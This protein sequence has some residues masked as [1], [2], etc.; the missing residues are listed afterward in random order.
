MIR[1][2]AGAQAR[3]LKSVGPAV[4]LYA[5][6]LECLEACGPDRPGCRLSDVHRNKPIA[7]RLGAG[8][9]TIKVRRGRV[10]EEIQADSVAELVVLD[11]AAR[12]RATIVPSP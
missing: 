4:E 1:R 2:S 10:R 6:A 9:R 8:E 11:Q 5:D 3:L 12:V 7:A